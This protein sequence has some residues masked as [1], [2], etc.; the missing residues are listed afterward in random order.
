MPT[1]NSP[2]TS[3]LRSVHSSVQKSTV[4][5]RNVQACSVAQ[6]CPTLCDPW[7]VT[8][9]S[10]LSMGFSRKE[11]WNGRPFPSP[12]DLPD[13]GIE[14]VFLASPALAGRILTAATGR[15]SR[16]VPRTVSTDGVEIEDFQDLFQP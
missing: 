16:N 7:P 14:P 11:Y 4:F 1:E 6:P 2:L 15:L 10:P 9:Q 8:H 5:V 3:T 12:G 13:P